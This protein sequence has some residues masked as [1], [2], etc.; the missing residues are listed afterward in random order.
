MTARSETKTGGSGALIERPDRRRYKRVP[1]ALSGRYMLEDG[2]EHA[3]ECIDVS[4]GG[5][6]LRAAKAGPWGSRVIAYIDGIGRIEGHLVRRAPGWF[7]IETRGT[8][9][10]EERV[11]ERIAWILDSEIVKQDGRRRLSRQYHERQTVCLAAIDGRQHRAELT[12]VSRDGAAL[13]MEN[14]MA[15][16][17]RV[18]L[19]GRRARVVRTFPGGVALKFENWVEDVRDRCKTFA[20]TCEPRARR[21]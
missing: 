6:R 11:E 5:L 19:D 3:C 20:P 2:S 18:R 14:V 13:L 16:G 15:V 12:D 8:S 21:A 4:A 10:K 17:E 7:A 1:V 9:R